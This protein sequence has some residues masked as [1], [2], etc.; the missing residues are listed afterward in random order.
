[1]SVFGTA[2]SAGTFRL[3]VEC[4][5]RSAMDAYRPVLVARLRVTHPG[6][7]ATEFTGSEDL[8]L[9]VYRFVSSTRF[10]SPRCVAAQSRIA[11]TNSSGAS[12]ST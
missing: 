9:A 2:R 7:A 3:A 8:D 11:A 10:T 4:L 6:S 5:G 12:D 1:M